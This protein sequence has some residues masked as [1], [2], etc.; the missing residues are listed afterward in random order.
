MNDAIPTAWLVLGL[1]GQGLFASRFL[2]QWLVSERRGASVVPVPF[3]WL[4]IGGGLCLLVYAILRR[5]P[6]IV[7]G[8]ASGLIVYARN[9]VLIRRQGA[10]AVPAVP[11][12]AAPPPAD[13]RRSSRA[14]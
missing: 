14:K 12:P 8:Q 9:L 7:L 5:D 3:W 2:I 11:T 13:D 1:I 6:V 4:S 10:A